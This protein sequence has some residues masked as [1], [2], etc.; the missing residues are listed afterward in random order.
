MK[1]IFNWTFGSIFRTFGRLL[2]YLFIGYLFFSFIDF[3]SFNLT[4]LLGL[5]YVKA[6]V[7][8]DNC[9]YI[10]MTSDNLSKYYTGGTL[11]SEG[12]TVV[13]TN[14]GLM[15][16]FNN[17]N[18]SLEYTVNLNAS[19]TGLSIPDDS[20]YLY[21]PYSVTNRTFGKFNGDG[22][23]TNDGTMSSSPNNQGNIITNSDGSITFTYS[24]TTAQLE[25]FVIQSA[26][27]DYV[28]GIST[29]FGTYLKRGSNKNFT[30]LAIK[31]TIPGRSV[32]KVFIPNRI[33][34]CN[35]QSS[36]LIQQQQETNNRIQEQTQQQHQ[37]SQNTQNA[38]N[39]VK[40]SI[41]NDNVDD[42]TN[43][44][45]NFFNNFTTDT[46]GLTGIITAPL[47][48]IQS[49]T[50]K[51][52]SPLVLPLP[53]VDKD[54]TLPCMREIYVDNFGAFMNI[55]DVITLG[56]ISYWILV[57]IFALVKDF[58]NPDHDEIEVMDL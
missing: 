27:S 57:R 28:P 39:G 48:A 42:S 45:S 4:D 15:Y 22:S 49:L 2:V 18:S 35:S 20:K 12:Q 40:D 54:L 29:M 21:I 6:E 3:K 50:S 55:Y 37:D 11:P 38:I 41:N 36:V 47:N 7:V 56:I 9:T 46:H 8:D 5:E 10:R 19:L 25:S 53:F 1:K 16:T 13:Y 44:A 43:T 17:Y 23:T 30:D 26:Y 14:D 33:L 34:S 51:T 52:C 24:G 31:F 58:K 32:I